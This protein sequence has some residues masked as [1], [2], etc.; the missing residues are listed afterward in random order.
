M[1]QGGNLDELGRRGSRKKQVEGLRYLTRGACPSAVRLAGC[2]ARSTRQGPGQ[3]R[4]SLEATAVAEGSSR[5][6]SSG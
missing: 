6:V 2:C 4:G 5:Q 3:K 1:R